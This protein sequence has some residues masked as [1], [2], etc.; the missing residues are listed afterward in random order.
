MS[1]HV[2]PSFLDFLRGGTQ[3]H[4]TVAVD[5]TASNGDPRTP[6][7]LHYRQPGVE[8]QYSIAIK[9]VGEIVQDYD[10]DKLFPA[11]GFGGRIPPNWDVSHEFYLNGSVDNPYCQGVQGILEA[12]G[13]S[14]NSVGLYGPTNFAPVIN[15][16]A[17]FAHAHQ[18]GKNYFVLL[19]ITDGIISDLQ[20]T[21]QALVNASNLPMSVVIV[22]VGNEDFATMEELD[23]DEHRLSSG[24][25]YA[26]RDIVQ[27]VELR[28]HLYQS[29]GRSMNS[30]QV[31]QVLLGK[32][33]LAEIPN[34]LQSWMKSRNIRPSD[35]VVQV[36]PGM[37]RI[38]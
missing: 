19:I 30:S 29:G 8:N 21:K 12:Y 15:H 16:V 5:F 38:H 23:G 25:T 33:V 10:S 7:S 2:E 27:F 18:D 20:A 37:Q 34:Q 1:A 32:D 4:F 13:R 17:R 31:S 6:A 36:T 35:P 9:A 22:G 28:K 14:L 26:A 11:L 3:I 24:G